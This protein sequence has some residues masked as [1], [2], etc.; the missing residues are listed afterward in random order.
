MAA[1]KTTRKKSSTKP[2]G[3]R[4]VTSAKKTGKKVARSGKS[5]A[6][7]ATAAA[8]KVPHNAKKVA[9]GAQNVGRI[10]STIGRLV[11]AGGEAAEDL[12]IEV[13]SRGR[14]SSGKSPKPGRPKKDSPRK[15]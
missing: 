10:V 12:A 3:T 14:K 9:R 5:F 2:R 15:G 4:A 13:E 7:K 8:S 1:K 6:K 11:E